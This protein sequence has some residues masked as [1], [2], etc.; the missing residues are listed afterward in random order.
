V[1]HS[2]EGLRLDGSTDTPAGGATA[3]IAAMATRTKKSD[4]PQ[5]SEQGAQILRA[6]PPLDECLKA[7]SRDEMLN[8]FGREYLKLILRRVQSGVRAAAVAG[9]GQVEPS[10]DWML[11]EVM[12]RARALV[13]ADEPALRPVINASGVVLHTNLGRALLAESAI[14]AV[15]QAA[16]S[17]VNLEYDLE[18]GERGDRDDIVEEELCALTG[19]EAATV[20]N[21]N[22][23]AVLLALNT[24]ADG[25]E[26]IVSRGELI[27]I[28]GS[29]RIPDVMARSGARLCEVGT[30]NRTHLRDYAAAINPA[31][32]LL[33]K[34]HPSNYRIVGFTAAV[35]VG[36]LA[37]LARSHNL[38]VMEDL[39]AGAL[40]DLSTYGLRREPIVRERIAAGVAL[41]TFSGDKLLGGPQA[42]IVVGRRALI[43]R[44]KANPL[45]RALRC[46]K[47]TLAALEGTLRLYLRSR[48]LAADLPT[49]RML[50]RTTGE[51]EAVSV[52]ARELLAERLGAD[53]RLEIVDSTSEIGS[54]SLP[55]EELK[56]R[57]IRITHATKPPGAIA[58]MFR[59]AR[60]P[61]IGRIQN[62]AFVLDLRTVEDPA[63]LALQFPPIA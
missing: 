9:A 30:T 20:V 54:G 5:L 60:P 31:T 40:I 26:V 56:T 57:A 55:T 39:G 13:A 36:E 43:A 38:D 17:A 18:S 1:R 16:R 15:E 10:R 50:R 6:L 35:E 27:E 47:L 58:T 25:R 21:N 28:G 37:E 44:L 3:I 33:L 41:V 2:R 29:F 53:F 32:A 63:S 62:G 14:A 45:K 22:A 46:D 34:V 42:G 49:L 11:E 23:A 48:D 61:V 4:R 52:R 8:S 7:A 51:I 12:R 19:A 24:L 59:R